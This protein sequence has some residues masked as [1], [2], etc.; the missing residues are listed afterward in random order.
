MLQ[1]KNIEHLTKTFEN[2]RNIKNVSIT[3]GVSNIQ[4]AGQ[5]RPTKL[6]N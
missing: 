3:A 5:I 1:K 2:N 4:P 6:F